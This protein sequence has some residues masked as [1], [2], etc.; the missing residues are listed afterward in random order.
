MFS[1]LHIAVTNEPKYALGVIRLAS[2]PWLLDIQ[3]D[4]G[5]TAMH[6]AALSGQS[7]IIRTLLMFGAKV[8]GTEITKNGYLKTTNKKKE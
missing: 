5:Q 7:N 1:Q 8:S 3:N 4:Y 6:L 2:A